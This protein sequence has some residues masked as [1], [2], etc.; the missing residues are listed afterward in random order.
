MLDQT[1]LDA[2]G[3]SGKYL[4]LDTPEYAGVIHDQWIIERLLAQGGIRLAGVLNY[5]FAPLE[6]GGFRAMT[7]MTDY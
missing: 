2:A 1:H 5:L 4:Q 6:D 7:V 3:G